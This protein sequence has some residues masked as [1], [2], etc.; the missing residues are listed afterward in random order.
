MFLFIAEYSSKKLNLDKSQTIN[1]KVCQNGF[2]CDFEI[3]TDTIDVPKN[4]DK[5]QYEY[6]LVTRNGVRSY[7]NN[8]YRNALQT[9]GLIACTGPSIEHCGKR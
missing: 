1:E 3:E 4:G 6:F 5:N 9:C 7:G 2:C 8:T